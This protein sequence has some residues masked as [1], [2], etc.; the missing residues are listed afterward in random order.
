[1]SKL[2]KKIT[3]NESATD[4][5]YKDLCETMEKQGVFAGCGNCDD[6]WI[7][8]KWE[9]EEDYL[10]WACAMFGT[11]NDTDESPRLRRD[12]R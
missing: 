12:S 8:G 9:D 5:A 4:A 3:L 7:I 1:M 10:D 6:K 2:K 11:P